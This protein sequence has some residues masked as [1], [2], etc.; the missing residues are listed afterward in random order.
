MQPIDDNLLLLCEHSNSS[1][2]LMPGKVTPAN[3]V[4]FRFYLAEG[5][6]TRRRKLIGVYISW[7]AWEFCISVTVQCYA[8]CLGD[9]K[10]AHRAHRDRGLVLVC[11][12]DF[13]GSDRK[14]KPQPLQLPG[15]QRNPCCRLFTERCPSAVVLN[16]RTRPFNR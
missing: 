10:S 7:Q 15:R 3:H 5:N 4:S 13:T 14:G 2:L 16:R 6:R 12:V 9:S 1:F 8:S 11:G